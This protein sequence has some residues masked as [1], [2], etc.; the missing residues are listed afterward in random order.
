[1]KIEKEEEYCTSE[2]HEFS[3]QTIFPGNEKEI[4]VYFL[5]ILFP[6]GNLVSSEEIVKNLQFY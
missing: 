4:V 1:M 2:K 5:G 6:I 3:H